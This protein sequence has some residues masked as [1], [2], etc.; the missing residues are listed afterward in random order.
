MS[1]DFFDELD[2]AGRP[3]DEGAR[4]GPPALVLR[5]TSWPS[6]RARTSSHRVSNSARL[7]SGRDWS[8]AQAPICESRP[9]LAK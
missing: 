8:D 1:A 4:R 6:Y 3:E 5:G 7:A 9:R 2:A